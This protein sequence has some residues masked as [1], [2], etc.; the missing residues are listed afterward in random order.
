MKL[1]T[2]V[3]SNSSQRVEWALHYKNIN[4]SKVEYENLVEG[5]LLNVNPLG[6]IPVL[7]ND[8]LVLTESMA[9]CEYLEDS[10]PEKPLIFGTPEEKAKIREICEFV[11]A[12]IHPGQN[13]KTVY[14]YKGDL[15][16]E[17]KKALRRKWMSGQLRTLEALAFKESSFA[18]GKEFSLADIFVICIFNKA[19]SLGV[20]ESQFGKLKRLKKSISCSTLS[21]S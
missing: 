3:S 7:V 12:T 10:F 9:I 16:K 2:S 4:Y 6:R 20:D 13:S 17:E 14:F 8:D 19:I 5:E 15:T 21:Y 18:V 1:Y 11:N